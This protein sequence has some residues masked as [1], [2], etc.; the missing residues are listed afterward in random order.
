MNRI[1]NYTWSEFFIALVLFGLILLNTGCEG[2]IDTGDTDLV[3]RKTV[4]N[5]APD[6]GDTINFTVTVT[7]NGPNQATNVSLND[8]LP[9]GLTA[10]AITPS[11]GSYTAPTWTVG[12]LNILASATLTLQVTVDAGTTGSTITNTV[13]NVTL[14]QPD[15]NATA[16][17]LSESISVGISTDLW[18]VK[19]VDNSIPNEGDTITF[20]VTVT[21]NGPIQATN[22]ALDDTL[23]AGL[24]AG[25]ITPSQ[26]SYTAPTWTAG[27]LNIGTSATLTLQA[28]VDAG[29]SGNTITNTV[30]NV[31]LDQ[32]DSNATAD[33]LSESIIVSVI[34]RVS[35]DSTGNEGNQDSIHCSLNSDGQV[36]AFESSATNL[37]A[38]DVNGAS[39]IFVYDRSTGTPERVSVDSGGSEAN[40]N[41]INPA[42][43]SDGRYVAFES[44][45]T[46]L[47]AGDTLG[48]T[49][50]F[51]HDRITGATTRVSID[52]GGSEANNNSTNP[53]ISSD[54]RYVA[55]ESDA[56]NLVAGDTNGGKDIFVHDTSTG[57]TE[58]VS[59]AFDG[60]QADFSSAEPS[61][62]SD[63]RYVAFLSS[64]TNLVPNDTNALDDVFV[65]DRSAGTTERISIASDG[66]QAAG[67]GSN[68]QPSINADGR[69]VAFASGSNN[70]VPN[71]T[72]GQLD[73][74]V[75][76]RTLSTTVRVSVAADGTEG[77]DWSMGPSISSDGLYVAFESAATNLIG[78]DTNNR[79]DIFVAPVP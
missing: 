46:N 39:D 55:F 3:V 64:A 69:Y 31:S 75:H 56:T 71:D 57:I 19:T 51:V 8:A 1:I 27:T 68:S 29:T 48:F 54:G 66:S 7:N 76:D 62:N 70:L 44:D 14:D 21:N 47:V 53:A 28:T 25:A 5:P 13:T 50:I 52:S 42:I 20:T 33:D 18:V 67:P 35:V 17:D 22:V 41:S 40:N 61:I 30:T 37:I 49:D 4:D 23:P 15:S 26:G 24:T 16:D 58:R 9:A 38:G 36:V 10:L 6:E 74:L 34:Q 11:Q 73:T 65:R 43:S 2:G 63:G 32:I 59:I 72:N 12:T 45:A 77:D 60:S 78:N 79:S